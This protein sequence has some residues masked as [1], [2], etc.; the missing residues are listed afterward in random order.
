MLRPLTTTCRQAHSLDGLWDFAFETTTSENYRNGFVPQKS[1][2]VPSSINDL[3][4]SDRERLHSDGIWYQKKFYADKTHHHDTVVIYFAGAS[5]RAEV[6]CNGQLI[7]HHEGGYLPFTAD[8]T[9][10]INWDGEN[11]LTV[12]LDNQLSNETIPQG[13]LSLEG[14]SWIFNSQLPRVPFDFFP[15]AGIQRSVH[16]CYLP[17]SRIAEFKVE[18]YLTSDTTATVK[19]YGQIA[20]DAD[21]IGLKL[22]QQEYQ[23]SINDNWFAFSVIIDNPQLWDIGCGNLYPFELCLYDNH[24]SNNDHFSR[25]G[26][27]IDHYHSRL[28]IREIAVSGNQLLLNKRPIYLQGF[29]KHEDFFISGKGNNNAVNVRDFE[30]MQWINANSFRT[31]HYPYAEEL[32]DLADEYGILVISETPAVSLNTDQA[33]ENT[34]QT[35]LTM[36]E[37]LI[38]RDYNHPSVIM[39]S[40]ANEPRSHQESSH[41]Y[42]KPLAELTKKLDKTRPNTLVSCWAPDCHALQWF[43]VVSINTYPGWYLL[44]GNIP[45]AVKFARE[46]LSKI[47]EKFAGP[48]IVTEF[49]ADTLP[50]YHALP[51]E[52]WSEEYQSELLIE[53]IEAFR[54]L[55]FVAGEHIWNFADFRTAQHHI[56]AGGNKKGLFTR[57]RQPKMAAHLVRKKWQATIK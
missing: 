40:V 51:A 11:L 49:G 43:D 42:F 35:H 22:N 5:Y 37:E 20:G 9:T 28:G 13:N 44:P 10:A 3:F 4:V 19:I 7:T 36:L 30:L 1:V 8:I 53:L 54:S 46:H 26:Q 17:K 12:R 32:L 50:G 57:E 34:L 15:Y 31:S 27:L 41:D 18:T 38:A 33:T 16:L 55:D 24:V 21:Y 14:D 52:M 2:P 23:V 29:G 56:R 45:E 6:F 25:V 48:L 47:H 39:W